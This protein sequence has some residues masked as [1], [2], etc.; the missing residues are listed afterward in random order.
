MQQKFIFSGLLSA[1]AYMLIIFAPWRVPITIKKVATSTY[2][3]TDSLIN[4]A[5]LSPAQQLLAGIYDYALFLLLLPGLVITVHRLKGLSKRLHGMHLDDFW[6]TRFHD[7][8]QKEYS[9]CC[10]PWSYSSYK[11]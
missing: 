8:V 9:D 4:Y 2:E 5:P 11:D 10:Y 1:L 3:H 6:E 7:A